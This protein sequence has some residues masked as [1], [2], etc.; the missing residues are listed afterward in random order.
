M[1]PRIG[2]YRKSTR[3][4]SPGDRTMIHVLGRRSALWAALI[5][6]ACSFV[7]PDAGAAPAGRFAFSIVSTNYRDLDGDHDPFPDTGETG[8]IVFTIRNGAVAQYGVSFV[9]ESSDP[10]VACIT[11]RRVATSDLAPGQ[12]IIVGSL[13]P[14]QPGFTFRTSDSLDSASGADPARIELC[15][16]MQAGLFGSLSDPVC[17]SLPARLDLP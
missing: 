7:V 1:A 17:V 3:R 16:R 14:A 12:Q 13:D 9:L 2:V 15:L 5:C 8:R 6:L 11:E 4:L 10:D